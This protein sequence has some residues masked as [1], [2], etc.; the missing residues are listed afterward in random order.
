MNGGGQG[1]G[2][3]CDKRERLRCWEMGQPTKRE[4]RNMRQRCDKRQRH[5]KRR[6]WMSPWTTGGASR[7]KV[8]APQNAGWMHQ[9]SELAARWVAETA[10]RGRGWHRQ[11][12]E[13]GYSFEVWTVLGEKRV[14]CFFSKSPH[15]WRPSV[16]MAFLFLPKSVLWISIGAVLNY[17]ITIPTWMPKQIRS[18]EQNTNHKSSPQSR[19]HHDD[20]RKNVILNTLGVMWSIPY[21]KNCLVNRKTAIIV[22]LTLHV[23]IKEK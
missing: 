3:R 12:G 21:R 23:G 14:Q 17:H 20:V 19:N 1:A 15:L 10:A 11:R 6:R 9:R 16:Q 2:Q 5:S 22:E 7:Q 13:G 8:E 4:G 18:F